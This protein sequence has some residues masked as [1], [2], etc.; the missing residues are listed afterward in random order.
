MKLLKLS[1]TG[2]MCE[3]CLLYDNKEGS[4]LELLPTVPGRAFL[5]SS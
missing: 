5:R 1:W 3:D 4:E 2:K